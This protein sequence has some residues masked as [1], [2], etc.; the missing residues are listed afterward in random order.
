MHDKV[1]YLAFEF[2]THPTLYFLVCDLLEAGTDLRT[3][4]LFAWSPQSENHSDLSARLNA[5]AALHRQPS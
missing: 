4:Q 2:E 5:R 3:I 1:N